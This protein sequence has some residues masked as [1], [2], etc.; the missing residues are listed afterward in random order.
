MN[1]V[2]F[3]VLKGETLKEIQMNKPNPISWWS[4]DGGMLF[5]TESGKQFWMGHYQDCCESVYLEEI[6]G[7]LDD[8]I[9]NPLVMAEQVSN[10]EEYTNM[11]PKKEASKY[12]SE[13]WTFYKLA[14]YKGYVTLRWYGTSNGFYSESVS[15][16]EVKK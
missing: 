10:E 5:I 8:L 15:F 2:D 7:N 9:G 14:T 1:Y 4:S 6:S 3:S 11:L 13:T 12:C 16:E